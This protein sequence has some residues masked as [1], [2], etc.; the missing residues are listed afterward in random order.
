MII[1]RIGAVDI[2][3]KMADLEDALGEYQSDP[4]PSI[5]V[6]HDLQ[7]PGRTLTLIHEILHAISDQYGLDLPENTVRRL[8]TGLGQTLRDNPGLFLCFLTAFGNDLGDILASRESI[9]ALYGQK[10]P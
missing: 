3:V 8:E 2:P 9:L 1:L 10:A 6:Q 5:S 7:E 4:F